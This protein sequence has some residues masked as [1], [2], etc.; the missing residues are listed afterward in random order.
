MFGIEDSEIPLVEFTLSIDGGHLLDAVEMNGVANLLGEMMTRG[1]ANRTPAELQEKIASLGAEIDVVATEEAIVL[2]GETLA[3]N[4]QP[5]MDLVREILLEPR[6]D[7]DEFELAKAQIDSQLVALQAN[8][9]ELA[10]LASRYVTYGSHDIRARSVFGSRT[11]LAKLT[12][13]DLEAFY[14]TN[15][16]PRV[17]SFRIV[18]DVAKDDVL[19]ALSPLATGWAGQAAAQRPE[20]SKPEMPDSARVYF[21]DLPGAKQSVFM[22]THP[23]MLRTDEEYYPATVANYRLGGGSFASR[24][25]Q[26]LREGKGYTYGIN[27]RFNSSARSGSFDIFS[28][29][30]TN[31][32]REATELV[33]QIM[34]DYAD[35]FT[36]EDL[37]VT[38]SFFINSK[39]RQF[40]SF[41]AKLGILANVDLYDLPYDYVANENRIVE[42]MTVE[43]IRRLAENNILPD[44]MSYVIVGDAETQLERLAE[45]GL[46]EPVVITD[47][48]DQLIQ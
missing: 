45:L 28:Q 1:T 14:T 19:S 8:P 24:L 16:N 25:T 7:Q 29:V 17:S 32:T 43:E 38:K 5:V 26:E 39:A 23:A 2:R 10:R 4:F 9:I 48:V 20:V 40:E 33:R 46:G 11:S 47:R 6:W 30:R 44:Q 27:S 22:F 15:L 13:S 31:V 42:A 41:G 34:L 36:A 35:T 12:I 37:A 18:G 21:Y 3:R